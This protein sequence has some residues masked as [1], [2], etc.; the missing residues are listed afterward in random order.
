MTDAPSRAY[1]VAEA[2]A[3]LM[4]DLIKALRLPAWALPPPS[5]PDSF[6][7]ADAA[8][9]VPS[10]LPTRSGGKGREEVLESL[11]VGSSTLF[12]GHVLLLCPVMLDCL[13]TGSS[14]VRSSLAEVMQVRMATRH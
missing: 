13:A 7:E 11:R 3:L 2:H 5:Q 9:A 12:A 6:E 14:A 4:L 1:V 10:L 8:W